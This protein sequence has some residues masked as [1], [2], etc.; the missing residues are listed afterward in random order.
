MRLQGVLALEA[1]GRP[2]RPRIPLEVRNLIRQVSLA[3]P[4]WGAPRIYGEL[5]KVGIDVAQSTVAK[6]MV[7]GW[8]P[9]S[10]S[11]KAF[12]RNHA[13]G[14]ASV[15][16]FLAPTAAFKLLYAF[17]I[18]EHDRRQLVCI[19]VT[20]SPTADRIAR[21]ISEAFPWDMAPK[22]LICDHDG[23]CG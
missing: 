14:I 4:L 1:E 17:V 8:R 18:L 15:D 10:R 20:T 23:A 9:P 19:A 2:G 6:Y 16:F 11:W 5:L 7:K 3:N 22:Y 12:L 13:E 21:Q